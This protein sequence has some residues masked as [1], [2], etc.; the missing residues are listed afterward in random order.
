MLKRL[1]SELSRTA[2]DGTLMA[3]KTEWALQLAKLLEAHVTGAGGWRDHR[4]KVTIQKSHFGVDM[5]LESQRGWNCTID[6]SVD[7][8]HPRV[9]MRFNFTEGNESSSEGLPDLDS[10]DIDKLLGKPI[11]GSLAISDRYPAKE[12]Y[13]DI[14]LWISKQLQGRWMFKLAHADQ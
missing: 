2:N 6:I 13:K 3:V 5:Y 11:R 14:S 4:V 7:D 1:A 10:L 8:T 9:D 12:L